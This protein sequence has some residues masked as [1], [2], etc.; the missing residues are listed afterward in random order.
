[1]NIVIDQGNTSVK[2]A[3]FE[4]NTLLNLFHFEDFSE[5]VLQEIIRKHPLDA[6]ILCTVKQVDKA[7]F[8]YLDSLLSRFFVLNEQT[9]VP[10]VLD[11]QT[12]QT[13]GMDRIAAA[14]GAYRQKPG[15]NLLVIDAG[16]AI[17]FDYV[18]KEGRYKGGNISPGPE[19]RFKALHHFTDK[20][21]LLDEQGDVPALGYDTE[22]AIRAGVMAGIVREMDSY[23]EEYIKKQHVFTFLTGG[24]AFYFESKLKNPIFADG[25]LVL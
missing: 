11:Y 20:L 19:L 12:P 5:A 21:P 25:N 24:Y 7:V 1:M 18:D 16:T 17:T 8:S 13:L 14:M 6:G 15:E 2:I 4:E 3:L 9:P 23:I 10:L 22:T